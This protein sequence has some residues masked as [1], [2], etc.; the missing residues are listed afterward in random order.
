MAKTNHHFSRGKGLKTTKSFSRPVAS[1]LIVLAVTFGVLIVFR[2]RA[3]GVSYSLQPENGNKSVNIV[4]GTDAAA[5]GGS[6][7]QFKAAAVGGGGNPTGTFYIV[8][9]DIVGPDGNKFYPVGSNVGDVGGFNGNG[10]TTIGHSSD[11]VAW[12]WNTIRFNEWCTDSASWMPRAQWGYQGLLNQVDSV[13]Q[14]YTSKKIVVMI[15]CHDGTTNQ[16]QIDQFWTDVS[17]KYRSNPYVWF[18]AANEPGWADNAAWLTLQQRY[19]GLVRSQGAENIFVADSMNAGNDMGWNGA[20]VIYDP[21]MGPTL[22]Q[23]NRCNLLFSLHDYG[24]YGARAD[25]PTYLDNVKNAGLPLIVGEF[26][27]YYDGR[28]DANSTGQQYHD[29]S[30]AVFTY[31]PQRGIGLL[32]WHGTHN[33]GYSLKNDGGPFYEGGPSASLSWEGQQLW[34]ITHAKPNLGAYTGTYAP[35]NCPSAV[36]H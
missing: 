31:G 20:K 13:V 18:N 35:S 29:A 21:T 9:T 32:T 16:A 11:A 5:S 12:G 4:T 1:G 10:A 23:T 15:A 26:G 27:E 36:G 3:A 2:I 30:N 22:Q 24:G 7:V 33:D 25:M 6:Y 34:N 14:E 17:V 28:S 19:L 8:G